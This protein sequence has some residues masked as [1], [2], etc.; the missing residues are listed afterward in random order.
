MGENQET[1]QKLKPED[2]LSK[3]PNT[4]AFIFYRL[5]PI[6]SLFYILYVAH[7]EVVLDWHQFSRLWFV[8]ILAVSLFLSVIWY[9][10]KY[11]CSKLEESGSRQAWLDTLN[12]NIEKWVKRSGTGPSLCLSSPES[13]QR[14]I[15]SEKEAFSAYLAGSRKG[16]SLPYSPRESCFHATIIFGHL[17]GGIRL[18]SVDELPLSIQIIMWI[19]IVLLILSFPFFFGRLLWW[20]GLMGSSARKIR[21]ECKSIDLEVGGDMKKRLEWWIEAILK[22]ESNSDALAE[23]RMEFIIAPILRAIRC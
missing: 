10:R 13:N 8:F 5:Y 12:S 2:D 17:Y 18:T 9:G 6:G 22:E 21:K 11:D 23:E 4:I 20:C 14:S 16:L 3:I 19:V 1:P 7:T 15:Q